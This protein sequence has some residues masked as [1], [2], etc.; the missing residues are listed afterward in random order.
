MKLTVNQQRAV[1][2]DAKQTLVIAGSGSGKTAVLIKR[3]QHLLI[4]RRVDP[5]AIMVLTFTR[6]AAGEMRSRLHDWAEEQGHPAATEMVERLTLGTFHKVALGFLRTHG[7]LMDYKTDELGIVPIDDVELL[8]KRISQELGYFREGKDGKD[9][10]WKAGLSMTRVKKFVET[11]Y[12]EGFDS[13]GYQMQVI[14]YPRILQIFAEYRSQLKKMN[15]LDFGSILTETRRLFREHPEVLREYKSTYRHVLVDECQDC[16]RVQYNL[17]EQFVPPANLF[18]VGDPRQSIYG[19]R[20]ARPDLM[21]SMYGDAEIIHLEEN[22][23]SLP[24]IVE[25]SNLLIA[26]N[27]SLMV[28]PMI[29]ARPTPVELDAPGVDILTGR[30]EDIARHCI[31]MHD[32]DDEV[33]WDV[34]WSDIIVL[35]RTHRI[36]KY[37]SRSFAENKVPHHRVGDSFEICKTDEFKDIM[38]ALRLC[39]NPYDELAFLRIYKDLGLGDQLYTALK[40]EAAGMG[41]SCL[42]ALTKLGSRNTTTLYDE[43]QKASEE[44]SIRTN[45]RSLAESFAAYFGTDNHRSAGHFWARNCNRMSV[46]SALR[47]FAF[48]DSQDD[49]VD[50]DLVTLSTIHAAKGLEYPVVIVADMNEGILPKSQAI[51]SESEEDMEEERRVCY[52]AM[53]RAQ[54]RLIMHYRRPQDQHL[55]GETKTGKIYTK[56]PALPSRFLKECEVMDA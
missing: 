33:A 38:A 55:E 46:A 27:K 19:W 56:K 28:K 36:L 30:S 9:G 41:T 21:T 4:E 22:F 34:R 17:H 37:I 20:G 39:V 42:I 1:H 3:V 53:T 6:K 2:S 18:M 12:N 13:S 50:G 11:F 26:H 49:T 24:H 40:A 8:L 44:N 45:A 32:T 52:V 51:N 43:I 15:L 10:K 48:M 23:R 47:W 7:D 31:A 54:D 35:A 29:A 14:K 5:F 25:T 16:D